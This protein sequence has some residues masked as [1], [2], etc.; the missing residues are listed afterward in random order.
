MTKYNSENLQHRSHLASDVLNL[1]IKEDFK[2]DRVTKRSWQFVCSR[3]SRCTPGEKILVYTSI[4]KVTGAMSLGGSDRIRV[5][6][7]SSNMKFERIARI[8]RTGGILEIQCRIS[9]A[10]KKAQNK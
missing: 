1:L 3:E 6:R 2:I 8:D 9:K 10:I 4:E 5:I 7:Q